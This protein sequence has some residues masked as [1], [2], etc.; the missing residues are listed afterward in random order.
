VLELG[1]SDAYVILEDADLD[2]T[3]E[4]CVTGRLINGGQSC[5]AAKRFVVPKRIR[6]EF[7]A[8][9]VRR[10]SAATMGDPLGEDC[11]IG[12]QARHDLRDELHEQVERSVAAGALLLLGGRIPEGPGAFYPPTVLSDVRPGM[13][14]YDEELFGPVAAILPVEDEEQ[15]IRVANDSDFG[16]G[17]AVFTRDLARGEQIAARRLEAGCCFVNAFV[18][19][20]PRLPFGGIKQSGYGRELG[21]CGIREFVNVK[22]VWVK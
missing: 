5:I 17:A 19:S 8:R 18:K 1:G 3:V 6:G 16:L 12:P 9:L 15:A 2:S 20:D 11:D 13:P 21:R 4:A 7:E 10:M 14:A 22:T